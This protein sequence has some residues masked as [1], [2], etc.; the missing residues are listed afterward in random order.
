VTVGKSRVFRLEAERRWRWERRWCGICGHRIR[1]PYSLETNR[2]PDHSDDLID[3]EHK[4]RPAK[5]SADE[6]G[7]LRRVYALRNGERRR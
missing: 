1:W 5:L 7:E 3:A 4:A 6:A 2:E